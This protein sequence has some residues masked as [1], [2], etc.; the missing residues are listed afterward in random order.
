MSTSTV[1]ATETTTDETGTTTGPRRTP[2]GI[3]AFAAL[4]AM[5]CYGFGIG[6]DYYGAL[7]GPDPES[8]PQAQPVREER[9]ERK[10]HTEH[11][12]FGRGLVA[13]AAGLGRVFGFG[14]TPAGAAR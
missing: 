1:E 5:D 11:T 12:G 7:Y 13:A 8:D 10:E 4:A 14:G 3:E 6:Y 9:R 2:R